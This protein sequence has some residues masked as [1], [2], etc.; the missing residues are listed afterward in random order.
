MIVESISVPEYNEYKA[1]EFSMNEAK[2]RMEQ[3]KAGTRWM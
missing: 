1:A 2:K 3:R